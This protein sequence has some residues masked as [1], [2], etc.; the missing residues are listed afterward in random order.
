MQF[1]RGD[2]P[3]MEKPA[4]FAGFFEE[5]PRF[6]LGMVVL[7][8]TALPLGDGSNDGAFLSTGFGGVETA[9]PGSERWRA[10]APVHT[11]V[12][13]VDGAIADR[14]GGVRADQRGGAVRE[15]R[16]AVW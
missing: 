10:Y 14:G 3:K 13:A 9:R 8:T 16:G 1:L 2:A 11:L 12:Y 6:E 5:P 7:Q 15:A 4:G